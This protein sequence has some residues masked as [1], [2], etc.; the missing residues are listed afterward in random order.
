MSTSSHLSPPA[1]R[2]S[3]ALAP[4]TDPDAA[5]T[6]TGSGASTSVAHRRT[7][8]ALGIVTAVGAAV[9]AVGFLSGT[10]DLG[11]EILARTPFASWVW[12]GVALAVLVGVPTAV[13]AVAALRRSRRTPGL[14]VGS[15]LVLAG[16]IAAQPVWLH[17]VHPFTVVFALVAVALVGLG[18]RGRSRPRTVR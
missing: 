4:A 6:I 2:P 17:V 10:L 8:A 16:W 3:Q 1:P 13:T 12:P 5:G 14:A 9:G 11:A 7:L 15:G 18:L